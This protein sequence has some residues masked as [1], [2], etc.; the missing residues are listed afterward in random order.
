[1][2][3]KFTKNVTAAEANTDIATSILAYLHQ[4]PQAADTLRGIVNWWLPQQS[5]EAGYQHVEEALAALVF[6]G[7]LYSTELPN[8]EVLYA[9]NRPTKPRPPN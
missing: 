7:K 3:N 6:E 4:H 2:S 5:R 9:L 1:M 8:G